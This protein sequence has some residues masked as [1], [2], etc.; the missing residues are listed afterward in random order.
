MDNDNLVKKKIASYYKNI[1]FKLNYIDRKVYG[2]EEGNLIIQEELL[3]EKPFMCV[4]L[5]AV[6]ARC[7]FSW[8]NNK[9]FSIKNIDSIHY[10][11]GV[12]PQD[13]DTIK[14]FCRVYSDALKDTDCL[15]L[16]S[17]VG[18]KKIMEMFCPSSKLIPLRSIEPYYHKEPWSKLLKNKRALVVHPFVESIRKQYERREKIFSDNRILPEFKELLLV[19]AIQ[20]NAGSKSDFETWFDALDYMKNEISKLEFDIAII[21]AGAYGLPLASYVKSI[22]RQAIQMAGSTQILFGIKGRRWDDHPIISNFYNEYWIR[23]NTKETPPDINKVEGGS[24]W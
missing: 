16:W 7:L 21:G 6:E 19:K 8:I 2:E 13:E 5:G 9:S 14:K 10:A 3:A 11:A 18:E 22:G 12:F 24:Y 15:G 20:S 17:V 1:K 4:R 23:A